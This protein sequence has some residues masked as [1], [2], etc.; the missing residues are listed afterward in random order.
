MCAFDGGEPSGALV[1]ILVPES[2]GFTGHGEGSPAAFPHWPVLVVSDKT[3][4]SPYG[5][6]LDE[7][8]LQTM[9][10]LEVR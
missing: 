10:K 7:V 3:Q 5:G 4:I 6:K 9:S 2:G 1:A 8:L